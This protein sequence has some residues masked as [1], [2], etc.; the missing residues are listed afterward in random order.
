MKGLPALSHIMAVRHVV[1]T[2]SIIHDGG[3]E[4]VLIHPYENLSVTQLDLYTIVQTLVKI[5]Y[6]QIKSIDRI[7][8]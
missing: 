5:N 2:V 1:T 7:I 3:R 4:G 8:Q 6:D